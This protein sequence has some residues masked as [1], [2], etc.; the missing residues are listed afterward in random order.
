[1]EFKIYGKKNCSNCDKMKQI[2][3]DNKKDYIYYELDKDFKREDYNFFWESVDKENKQYP[4]IEYRGILIS[5]K[6]FIQVF[7]DEFLDGVIKEISYI[8]D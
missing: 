5:Y 6:L 3:I 7:L 2:C 1:M 8:K 4:I